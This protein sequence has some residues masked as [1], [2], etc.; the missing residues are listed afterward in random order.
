MGNNLDIERVTLMIDRPIGRQIVCG[1]QYHEGDA[2]AER[3]LFN[4]MD[5]LSR[6]VAD[7][8]TLLPRPH[9]QIKNTDLD[10]E[11]VVALAMLHHNGND[12][13]WYMGRETIEAWANEMFDGE[14]DDPDA[15]YSDFSEKMKDMI[16]TDDYQSDSANIAN[17]IKALNMFLYLSKPRPP[18]AAIRAAHRLGL[19]LKPG[20]GRLIFDC[21]PE[22][23]AADTG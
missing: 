18:E 13:D 6:F 8:V 9:D 12:A 1:W 11:W 10:W 19:T 5:G 17:E 23:A 2:D 7:A 21:E 16:W 3:L 4:S 22:P 14:D 15:L 20:E